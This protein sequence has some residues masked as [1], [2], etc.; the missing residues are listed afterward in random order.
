MGE[1]PT[2]EDIIKYHSQKTKLLV[3]ADSYLTPFEMTVLRYIEDG[4][5]FVSAVGGWGQSQWFRRQDVRVE[6]MFPPPVIVPVKEIQAKLSGIKP[7]D[8]V[9]FD[10]ITKDLGLAEKKKKRKKK[11]DK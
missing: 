11:N 8:S 4:E 9:M 7:F 1:T 6:A 3:S 2:C 10:Q 5:F